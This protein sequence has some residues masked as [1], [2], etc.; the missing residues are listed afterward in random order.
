MGPERGVRHNTVGARVK[1]PMYPMSPARTSC[2]LPVPSSPI[3]PPVRM[4]C[5][6]DSDTSP[7]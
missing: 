2:L 1:F 4:G 6:L 5:H 3:K 7:A